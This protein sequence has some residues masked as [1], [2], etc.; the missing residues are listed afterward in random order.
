MNL[1]EAGK[2]HDSSVQITQVHASALTI[3]ILNSGEKQQ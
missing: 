1:I 3:Y 2:R